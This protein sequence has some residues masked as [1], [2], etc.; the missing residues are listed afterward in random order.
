LVKE[1]QP[2]IATS[3]RGRNARRESAIT[4]GRGWAEKTVVVAREA[5]KLP[6]GKANR[7]EAN[8][9][10]ATREPRSGNRTLPEGKA[11]R[12]EANGEPATREPR[13][14]N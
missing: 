4:D 2:A 6:E 8:G 5:G 11:N 12:L 1:V 14:G 7:L 13:S 3:G 9:E 10:P